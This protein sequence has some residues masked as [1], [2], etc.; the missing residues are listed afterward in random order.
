MLV[1]PEKTCYSVYRLVL[2]MKHQQTWYLRSNF[3]GF[4]TVPTLWCHVLL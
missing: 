2:F 3:T 1:K 4:V